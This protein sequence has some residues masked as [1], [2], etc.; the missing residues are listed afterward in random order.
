MPLRLPGFTGTTCDINIDDCTP[1][2]CQNGGTC[3]DLVNDV[4]CECVEE[5]YGDFCEE[6]EDNC[7]GN[8]DCQNG[9]TC[10]DEHLGF[11]CICPLQY[12]GELCDKE[13]NPYFDLY[14]PGGG[15]GSVTQP[16]TITVSMQ[17]FT[18]CCWVRFAGQFNLGTFLVV[19][20]AG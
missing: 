14:F 1:G 11:S 12:F 4:S 3:T 7:D 2:I 17:E 9:A 8:A 15:S 10:V 5:Y 18:L 13:K 16:P 6:K 19:N 20:S